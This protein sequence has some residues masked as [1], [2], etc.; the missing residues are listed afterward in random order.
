MNLNI[1]KRNKN[2]KKFNSTQTYVDEDRIYLF[3]IF[4]EKRNKLKGSRSDGNIFG[5]LSKNYKE[6][7]KMNFNQIPLKY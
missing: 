5:K 3:N 6:N 2:N 7:Y 1:K 4:E